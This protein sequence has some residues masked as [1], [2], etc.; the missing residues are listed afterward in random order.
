MIL[1]DYGPLADLGNMHSTWE[2]SPFILNWSLKI[3]ITT[4]A[5]SEFETIAFAWREGVGT[6]GH[7]EGSGMTPL[8]PS[9]LTTATK[10]MNSI[11]AIP[12]IL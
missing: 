9:P 11:S 1:E 7:K 5:P 10:A 2:A 3:S 4:N 12:E 8:V 6:A